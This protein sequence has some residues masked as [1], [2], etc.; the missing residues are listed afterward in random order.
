MNVNKSIL[1]TG[2]YQLKLPDKIAIIFPAAAA[3]L[4]SNFYCTLNIDFSSEL[5]C[6]L[7]KY[8]PHFSIY[9]RC[10]NHRLR[11]SLK[12]FK[13]RDKNSLIAVCTRYVICH[14]MS[15]LTHRRAYFFLI[16]WRINL[17]AATL[18][19]IYKTALKIKLK[20]FWESSLGFSQNIFFCN[21]IVHFL[22][23]WQKFHALLVTS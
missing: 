1:L 15:N 21:K 18:R 5:F 17:F 2:Q 7:C 9:S 11:Q 14:Q 13:C 4:K 16:D 19:K 10:T 12:I 22:Q 23:L 3:L 8:F 20:Q 6:A